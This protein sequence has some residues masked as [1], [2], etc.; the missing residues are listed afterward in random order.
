MSKRVPIFTKIMFVGPQCNTI[1]I[2]VFD[3]LSYLFDF[4]GVEVP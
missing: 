2:G 1:D 4:F 3:Y